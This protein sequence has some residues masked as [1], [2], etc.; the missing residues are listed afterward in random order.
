[1]RYYTIMIDGEEKVAVSANGTELFLIPDVQ[2]MNALIISG[3]RVTSVDGLP[4]VEGDYR[5]LSPIPRP[6]QDV[7]CLGVNYASHGKEMWDAGKRDVAL[8]HPNPIFFAKRVNRANDPDGIIPIYPDLDPN[9][10]YEVEL[11]VVLGR[12]AKNVREEDVADYVFGYTIVNDISAR[13]T[14]SKHTQW[15]FGKSFDGYTPIGPCIVSAGE[16]AFPPVQRLACRV[17]G[18]VRQDSCTDRMITG[19]A[20]IVA[21]LSRGMTLLAGT[22][23]ATGTPDGVAAAMKPPRFLQDGD[24]VE[25]EIEGIGVLRNV[26]KTEAR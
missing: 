9:I 11:G 10:D 25:C 5:V 8:N 19:I 17:N 6:R 26:M 20:E 24:V 4:P 21:L 7:I 22:I 23:I 3:Q 1:M 13:I 12:D 2:D 14:Q 16:F 15:Y 18:E